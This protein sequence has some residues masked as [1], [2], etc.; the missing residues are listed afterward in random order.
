ML[1][2]AMYWQDNQQLTH[3]HGFQTWTDISVQQYE[4]GTKLGILMKGHGKTQASHQ[5]LPHSSIQLIIPDQ[6]RPKWVPWWLWLCC[7]PTASPDPPSWATTGSRRWGDCNTTTAS[8]VFF[9]L[10]S[11]S[12]Q[13]LA[14]SSLRILYSCY[15]AGVKHSDILTMKLR[16]RHETSHSRIW[17]GS[18]WQ[19]SEPIESRL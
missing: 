12:P 7:S 9:C 2:R 13:L 4:Q 18:L 14:T 5:S 15:T 16:G 6:K 10:I 17:R 11:P 1:A 19:M 8:K 3:Y